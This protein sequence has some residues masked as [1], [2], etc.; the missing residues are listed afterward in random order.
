[1][2]NREDQ[3]L[4]EEAYIVRRAGLLIANQVAMTSAMTMSLEFCCFVLVFWEFLAHDATT[5]KFLINI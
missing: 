3:F 1:M 4:K 2:K 5:Y